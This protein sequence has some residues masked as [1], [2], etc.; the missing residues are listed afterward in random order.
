ME[1]SGFTP[2]GALMQVPMS[3]E[4]SERQLT[5]KRTV[6]LIT[7]EFK[8]YGPVAYI[9]TTTSEEPEMQMR[10]RVF[11]VQLDE[12]EEQTRLIHYFQRMKRTRK[13]LELRRHHRS[14][15][16]EHR[17]FQSSLKSVEVIIPYAEHLTFPTRLPRLRRDHERFLD[18]IS[19]IAF[20]H[21]DRRRHSTCDGMTSIDA[22]VED[23]A[24]AYWLMMPI[25]NTVLDDLHPK[26][27]ELLM[28]IHAFVNEKASR[29]E[30]PMGEVYFTRRDLAERTGWHPKEVDRKMKV[31]EE[32]EYVERVSGS[33]GKQCQYRLVPGFT[34]RA[35]GQRLLTPAEL[36]QIWN[37]IGG[38]E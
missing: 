11:E 28:S 38:V 2:S 19:V 9:E 16:D 24:V 13:G 4:L 14:L 12:S 29:Q 8:V 17:C 21:Q 35:D 27:R 26:A 37:M 34:R 15:I 20:L 5:L 23:Y 32:S 22:A 3:S 10:N 6:G 7:M 1:N 30:K 31:L 25:L 18:L 33:R 36:W